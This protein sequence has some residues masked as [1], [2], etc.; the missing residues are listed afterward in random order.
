MTLGRN[1]GREGVKEFIIS[2][3][4]RASKTSINHPWEGYSFRL[5]PPHLALPNQVTTTVRAQ[6]PVLH[7]SRYTDPRKVPRSAPCWRVVVSGLLPLTNRLMLSVP[8]WHNKLKKKRYMGFSPR[9]RFFVN[10]NRDKDSC[11]V[12]SM[13]SRTMEIIRLSFIGYEAINLETKRTNYIYLSYHQRHILSM[14]PYF[15]YSKTANLHYGRQ[16]LTT[17]TTTIG[18]FEMYKSNSKAGF[19]FWRN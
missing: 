17:Q 18:H 8:D 10:R 6:L 12:L 7:L 4:L 14:H 19:S 11:L 16:L 15:S 2:C 1:W 13:N 5:D 9:I 3:S